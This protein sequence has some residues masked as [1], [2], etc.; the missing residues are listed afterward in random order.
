MRFRNESNSLWCWMLYRIVLADHFRSRTLFFPHNMDFR[1][2]VYPLSPYL[3]HMGDD[4]N[5]CILKFAKSQ[6]LGTGGLEWLKL[7]CI[8]LTGTMKRASVSDRM[9]EAERLLPTILDSARDPLGGEQWWMTSDEP[10]QTLAACVE[11]E[12]ALKYGGDVATFPSQLPVHQDGSCNGLQHYAALGRDNE[13]GVQVNLTLCDTPNDVY[14]DVAQRVELKRKQDEE[15]NGEDRDVALKLREALPQNVPRKVIKQTVMT[16][17]YGVTMYGAVLQIKRQLKALDIPGEDAAVFA[18]YLA[19]K[20]FASLNDAF[21]S[22]MALK[23]WFRLIAKGASDL[24]KTVEWVTP[25][26]LPVVQPYCRLVERRSKL[27]LAPIPMK[28]VDAFPPNFVHSLDSTHMMLTS[29]NC[30]H[31][32]ITFAAVHDCFWTHANS[33]DEMNRICRQQFVSLHSEPIVEQCSEWFKKTYLTPKIQRILPPSEL[34]KYTDIFTAKAANLGFGIAISGGRDNPH[35]TSGDPVVVI[36]DVVPNGPAWGLL[37][38]NDRILS[39]NN[40]SFENIDYSSAVDIIKNKDHIDM[41]VKRRV[42]VPML[43]YEQRTLKFTLSKS[44]KKDDFGIVVGCKF[45]IKEIR[46]PKLAEKDPGLKEGDSVIRINGQSVEDASLEEVNKWL[47]RSRDKLC[48][49]IQRDVR[50]GTSRWPSQNTVYE[51]V[52]SVGATPRHSPSPMLPHMPIAQR[53]SHEYVNSPRHRSDGSVERRVSSPAN[54]QLSNFN[55]MASSQITTQEYDCYTRQPSRSIDGNGVA[56]IVFRKVG[57]SVGVRVIGGNEVG[58]FVSAVA[59]DSPASLH[60]VSCGDRILEVN[61]RSMRGI[62][63]ESAVQL[64]LGLDDRVQLKLEHARQDYDHVRANQLGDNFYI[65]THFSR[66]KREKASQFEM[67]INEGDIF[68]VTDTLFGGTVGLWQAA[69]VYSSVEN[70]GEPLKGVIPNQATAEQIAKEWRVYVEQKQAKSSGGSG[71]LLRR[72]FE[73]RRTK[74]LPKNMICDPNELNLPVPAYER[75]ALNTPSFHRP[76]VLFGPLADIARHQLLNQFSARFAA[77]ESDGG[78]IRLSSVDHVIA[79]MKHCVLDISIESVERLQLAQY[80]PIVV[81]LDVDGRSRIRE[82]RKKCNAPHLSSRKLAD[83]ANQIKKH[84]SHLLSATVDATNES[85]WFDALRELIGHLQQRRLWM[86]E[87]PPNLPLEDVLLFPLPKY[88][89]DVDSLKSDYVDYNS[90]E[91]SLPRKPDKYSWDNDYSTMPRHQLQP[92]FEGRSRQSSNSQSTLS[93][94]VTT[95]S[96]PQRPL[97][98]PTRDESRTTTPHGYYHV[99]Q[100]LDDD[101]LYQDARLANEIANARLREEAKLREERVN[102][103]RIEQSPSTLPHRLDNTTPNNFDF[104]NLP[105]NGAPSSTITANNTR[106]HPLT[107]S[108]MTSS[109]S[110]A[111][112]QQ[113][114]PNTQTPPPPRPPPVTSNPYALSYTRNKWNNDSTIDAR[115]ADDQPPAVPARTNGSASPA[116]ASISLTVSNVPTGSSIASKSPTPHLDENENGRKSEEEEPT[117]VEESTAL[118]GTQGGVIRCEKSNVELRIPPG[119]IADGEEHEIYVKVCREG[120][121]S[122]IDRSKGETLLSP[123]V[124]CGPQGK[125]VRIIEMSNGRLAG[126]LSRLR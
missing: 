46:N 47:E 96:A 80:A 93:T 13:G 92:E 107:P 30:A 10:W 79:A 102:R 109:S 118:I 8:N 15:S 12:Q 123:L 9:V 55:G 31:R 44:R 21:T 106:Y 14:S 18:R 4:V 68:H 54:S 72:K 88:E 122:P 58:I 111:S 98:T 95:P 77:P 110:G 117:V 104:S 103:Q 26:G 119:A 39:A 19:R 41:I 52:G 20:T 121:S 45:Y 37:Q 60:G 6:P 28:Q 25:L 105:T 7:H 23:D 82:I 90:R 94:F 40:V 22:S 124:M 43:E 101:S 70:K 59:A 3:S 2:R 33:V 78:V 48:L 42:A 29:L 126:T 113:P 65:R 67:S 81:F 114:P 5:R 115:G 91:D 66:E 64:L 11:I 57:G 116:N 83:H 86:P 75:V 74:S 112:R 24:M 51:R 125:D 32:G 50:R 99:K 34:S 17:V 49:V 100:L 108:S 35:F 85:G 71:T 53:N 38:V 61:G 87:F 120:D 76:L 27:V 36:S 89:G 84:H 16:T 73:S 56:N 69:R 63:R 1:G 62:T 97:L